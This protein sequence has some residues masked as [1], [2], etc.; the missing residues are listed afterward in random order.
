MSRSHLQ[1]EFGLTQIVVVAAVKLP[2][3]KQDLSM[4]AVFL[5]ILVSSL[6]V[7]LKPVPRTAASPASIFKL[8]A[9]A[10]DPRG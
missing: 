10:R 9:K 3:L 1:N 5:L 4:K 8:P 2:G 7:Q 6:L